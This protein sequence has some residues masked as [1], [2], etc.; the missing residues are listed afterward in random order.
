VNQQDPVDRLY[1]RAFQL[2][3]MKAAQFRAAE[4]DAADELGSMALAT[5]GGGREALHIAR[6][7]CRD[8]LVGEAEGDPEAVL[9]HRLLQLA[10]APGEPQT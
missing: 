5:R 8:A 3:R 6:D 2:A 1:H 4:R 7:R 10:L 9:A